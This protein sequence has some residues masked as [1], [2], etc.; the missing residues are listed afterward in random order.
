MEY[1]NQEEK[2]D[3]LLAQEA[4]ENEHFDN[5]EEQDFDQDED[6]FEDEFE[7]EG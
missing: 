4:Y 3:E 6:E 1:E 2:I 5:D 7:D